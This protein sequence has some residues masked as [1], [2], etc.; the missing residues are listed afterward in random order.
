MGQDKKF[1]SKELWNAISLLSQQDMYSVTIYQFVENYIN[2]LL[3]LSPKERKLKMEIDD[4]V[5]ESGG[6]DRLNLISSETGIVIATHENRC[7]VSIEN[8]NYPIIQL[9]FP[10]SYELITQ[11]NLIELERD[12]LK[13]LTEHVVVDTLI[14]DSIN[15]EELQEVASCLY[16]QEGSFYQIKEINDN[17]FYKNK[18]GECE[19]VYQPDYII[20]SVFNSLL[21]KNVSCDLSIKLTIRLYGFKKEVLEIPLKQLIDYF[22]MKGCKLY[23]GIEKLESESL[24]AGVFIVNDIFKYNHILTIDFPYILLGEP[25][26]TIAGDL[27]IYI[28][29]H[30]I[31]SIFT[32]NE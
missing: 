17:L 26:G 21:S 24:T 6:L 32:E 10:L 19:L 9:A 23:V 13:E 8:D 4:V 2:Q 16:V 12:F 7:K 25:A 15:P 30:N 11:K 29:T 14:Q 3:A 18:D 20:E 22:E 27:M 31:Q 28:P 1:E 5:I